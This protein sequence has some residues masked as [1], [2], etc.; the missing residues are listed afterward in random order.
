MRWKAIMVHHTRHRLHSFLH[1]AS[2]SHGWYLRLEVY[3][4]IR[5]IPSSFDRTHTARISVELFSHVE[6]ISMK[7]MAGRN[8]NQR[9][10]MEIDKLFFRLT[11]YQSLARFLPLYSL[12]SFDRL[13][14][15][16]ENF[17]K[18]STFWHTFAIHR[19]ALSTSSMSWKED[20]WKIEKLIIL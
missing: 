16:S 7:L 10:T 20:D 17:H 15:N 2:M 13:R 4:I 18:T 19:R 12:S 6:G 14:Q 5:N 1:V 11:L 9:R 3:L 8:D